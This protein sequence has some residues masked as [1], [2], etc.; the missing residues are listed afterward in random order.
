M[1]AALLLA[2]LVSAGPDPGETS[3]PT[4]SA[5]FALVEITPPLG[6]R[7]A[8]SYYEQFAQEVHD[9]LHVRCAYLEDSAGG[10]ACLIVCDL[11]SLSREVADRVRAEVGRT[12]GVP[13]AAIVVAATH[14]H[15]AVLYDGPL[16]ELFHD[17]AMAADGKDAAEPIDFPRFLADRCLRAARGAEARKAP[18]TLAATA[19][20]VP[21]LSYNRRFF[22][23]DGS[24]RFNPG[25]QNPNIDRP[26]GPV[27]ETLTALWLEPAPSPYGDA[28]PGGVLTSWPMHTAVFTGDRLG[29]DFPGVMHR[30]LREEYG[31]GF[32]FLH[33]QGTSGNTNHIDVSQPGLGMDSADYSAVV[34]R[35]LAAALVDARDDAAPV[36]PVSIK[37]AKAVVPLRIRAFSDADLARSGERFERLGTGATPAFLELVDAYSVHLRRD[38]TERYGD[39]VPA[40]V[41]AI[42]LGENAA[43]VALPYEVF[44]EIGLDIKARSPFAHTLILTLDGSVDAY[45]PDRRAYPQG[46]YEVVNSPFAP[47]AGEALGDAAVRLLTELHAR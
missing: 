3:P 8:N 44:V 32:G 41:R 7:R 19:T 42:R 22:M 29:A 2:A 33:G 5:G 9:P 14:T 21:N 26:A 35:K 31:E 11:T 37:G 46:A 28:P 38:L 10:R 13:D 18:V 16:R 24:V 23:K 39:A 25:Y 15:G 40:E 45:V 6:M 34:G 47:G 27:D 4:L 12:L 20:Q 17:R 1:S 43:V 30:E 36:P